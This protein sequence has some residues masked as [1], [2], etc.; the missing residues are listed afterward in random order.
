MNCAALLRGLHPENAARYDTHA[1][2]ANRR[3]DQLVD[4]MVFSFTHSQEMRWM[5]PGITPTHKCVAVPLVAI[6]RFRDGKLAHAQVS[7]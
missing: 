2:V 7:R 1:G 5:L 4:E 3:E 6:V